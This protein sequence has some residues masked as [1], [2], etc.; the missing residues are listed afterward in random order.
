MWAR[1]IPEVVFTDSRRAAARQRQTPGLLGIIR[2][3]A[4]LL[5]PFR[6]AHQSGPVILSSTSSAEIAEP[7]FPHDPRMYVS[8]LAI[9]PEVKVG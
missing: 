5:K 7:P 6:P 4:P 2:T 1:G 8:T 9:S 3:D